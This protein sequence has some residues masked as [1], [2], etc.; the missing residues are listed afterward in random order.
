[1]YSTKPFLAKESSL[2]LYYSYIH[3]YLNYA[4]LSWGST[5][6]TN[7]K[8]LCS[9]QKHAIR[10][11]HNNTIICTIKKGN[12]SLLSKSLY[13]DILSSIVM[14]KSKNFAYFP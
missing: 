1:M 13:T 14:L 8:K 5:Y 9:Q 11:V 12:L 10:M 4:N 7:L 6:R 2:A 3:S